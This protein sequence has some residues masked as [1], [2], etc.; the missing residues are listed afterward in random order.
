MIAFISI[1]GQT[2][3]FLLIL[4]NQFGLLASIALR[5]FYGPGDF[6]RVKIRGPYAVGFREYHVDATE[7]A[8]SVFYPID[9]SYKKET[10]SLA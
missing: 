10:P 7:T 2:D 5:I 6:S 8:V 4:I 1:A 3:G 9:A